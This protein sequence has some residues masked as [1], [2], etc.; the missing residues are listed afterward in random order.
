M[1][2]FGVQGELKMTTFVMHCITNCI[3]SKTT[4]EQNKKVDS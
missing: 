2:F 1:I 4:K 3:A